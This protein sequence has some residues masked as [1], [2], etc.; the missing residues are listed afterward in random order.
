[1]KRLIIFFCLVLAGCYADEWK[2]FVYPSK[3]NLLVHREIG[4]YSS[5]EECRSAALAV[6]SNAG[7]SNAD[8]ECGLNCELSDTGSGLNICEKTEQ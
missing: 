8:Y 2:G 7:W 6:I 1:M 3:A 5:L 4:A